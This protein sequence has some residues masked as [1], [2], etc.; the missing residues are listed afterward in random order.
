[1]S[2][3]RRCR[4]AFTLVELLVVIA[5]I[6]ILIALLLPAVQA[7][8]EAGRRSACSNNLRQL[9]LA[10]HGYHDVHQALPPSATERAVGTN[11][12]QVGWSWLALITPYIEEHA[13]N[14]RV[15]WAQRPHETPMVPV[16]NEFRSNVLFCPTRRS[17]GGVISMGPNQ[18]FGLA[19]RWLGQAMPT[20]YAA[21]RR[22]TWAR[23]DGMLTDPAAR[24]IGRKP[25]RS[26]T[27]FG[28]VTDGLSNTAMLGEKHMH[29]DWLWRAAREA[30]AVTGTCASFGE[31]QTRRMG[32]GGNQNVANG[33]ARTPRDSGPLPG[34]TDSGGRSIVINEQCFGSWHP[35]VCLFAL[36]DAAVRP[37]HNATDPTT[38]LEYLGSRND[39]FTF[40]FEN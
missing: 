3:F 31:F 39:G 12:E 35:A 16:V 4:R 13:W 6:G 28:S 15:N 18:L 9:A 37:V 32:F 5:I 14:Q 8:R 23:R 29:V 22:G 20:D 34:V 17:Q 30:P 36:G 1:M 33:L 26:Q 2:S 19:Q 7:A 10:V 21:V 11:V 40:N 25:A 24:P 27:T 38:V